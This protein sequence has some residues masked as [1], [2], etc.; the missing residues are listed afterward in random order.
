M[1]DITN[2]FH[3]CEYETVYRYNDDYHWLECKSKSCDKVKDKAEHVDEDL[4]GIC[5]TCHRGATLSIGDVNYNS[6][7]SAVA[8]I[9]DNTAT[10]LVLHKDLTESGFVV[11]DKKTIILDL[12]G[13]TFSPNVSVG[14]AGTPSNG[15]Q[16]LKGS[17]ILIKNGTLKATN[18]SNI[19]IQNY[20]NLTLE[21]V[22]LDGSSL[23][24]ISV[25][26]GNPTTCYTL[27]NNCG[28]VTIRGNTQ[29]VAKDGHY[30]FDLWYGLSKDYKDG[31][32]VT[33]DETFTGK[34][35]GKVEY[36][37][38]NTTSEWATDWKTK[39][40]LIIKSGDF[41]QATFSISIGCTMEEANITLPTGKQLQ[42]Q[43]T[44]KYKI[45]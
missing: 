31:V 14:S 7:A 16:F 11:T 12:N 38:G 32:S 25:S 4:N 18:K 19:L 26:N 36:G 35:I 21:N 20:A 10:E 8:S 45:V 17:I 9:P 27:S 40:K 15:F 42:E 28:T 37:A 1:D 33:F 34:V 30:A 29:I 24:D 13:H 23:N 5:D 43:S 3:E 39:T 22:T 2:L 6:M 44:N 41:S